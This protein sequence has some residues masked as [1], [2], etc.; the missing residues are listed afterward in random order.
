MPNKWDLSGMLIAL[1]M[2]H[3]LYHS[4]SLFLTLTLY[5]PLSASPGYLLVG[6]LLGEWDNLQ[7]LLLQLVLRP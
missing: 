6:Y 2:G 3:P 4:D 5:S 1:A 7:P